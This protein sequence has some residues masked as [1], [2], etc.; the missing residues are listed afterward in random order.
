MRAAA[1]GLLLA[2][3]ICN[4]MDSGYLISLPKKWL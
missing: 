3:V 4:Q 1:S 2:I